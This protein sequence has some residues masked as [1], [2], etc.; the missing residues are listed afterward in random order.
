MS[1]VAPSHR[2]NWGRSMAPAHACEKVSHRTQ[3][4]AEVVDS[5]ACVDYIDDVCARRG[6]EAYRTQ[7]MAVET[8][9]R[10]LVRRVGALPGQ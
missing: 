10:P 8:T 2:R 6:Y 4:G 7:S 3:E 1:P 5:L 9:P